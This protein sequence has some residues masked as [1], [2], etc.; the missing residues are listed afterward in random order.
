M[1]ETFSC[2]IPPEMRESVY[3]PVP[4]NCLSCF[5]PQ[6]HCLRLHPWGHLPG[7]NDVL[8][9]QNNILRIITPS[10]RQEHCT[11]LL[12]KLGI[13]TAYRHYVLLCL[14]QIRENLDTYNKRHDILKHNTQN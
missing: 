1:P 11:P 6:P 12:T 9:L 13:M 3:R 14:I 2:D 10:R 7:G 8:L 5:V 4:D